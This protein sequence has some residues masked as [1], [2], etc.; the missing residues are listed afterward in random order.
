ME[1]TLFIVGTAMFLLLV[2]G[3]HL[4]YREQQR[5]NEERHERKKRKNEY[6]T[7]QEFI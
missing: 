3:V 2:I 4:S 5:K 6:R 1:T 7:N